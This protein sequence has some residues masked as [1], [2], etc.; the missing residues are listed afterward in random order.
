[1]SDRS[2][3]K[4]VGNTTQ[5]QN[6]GTGEGNIFKDKI[7]GN[8]LRFRR[9]KEGAN[10]RI[11][12]DGDDIVISGSSGGGSVTGGTTTFT[13]L[14]DTPNT[15]VNSAS[16]WVRVNSLATALEFVNP[17]STVPG[18]VDG[19]IQY[20]NNGV[21]G[22]SGLCWDNSTNTY[23]MGVNADSNIL[24]NIS[25]NINYNNNPVFLSMGLRDSHPHLSKAFEFSVTEDMS[26]EIYLGGHF[27][28]LR[29]GGSIG[30]LAGSVDNWGGDTIIQGGNGTQGGNTFICG[31][32]GTQGGGSVTICSGRLADINIISSGSTN[33]ASGMGSINIQSILNITSRSTLP[34]TSLE[35]DI[36]RLRNH[37]TCP[38]GIYV[39]NGTTWQS[40]TIW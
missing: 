1:M 30:I 16:C 38:N 29:A 2:N 26:S 39:N 5:G 10:I 8:N 37:S 12:Q 18:G 4:L 7:G 25:T 13:G 35:G 9:I 14:I 19:S 34:S 15:Y 24:F 32:N 31:G 3:I 28:A 20:N 6:V 11:I 21:L 27:S 22:G 36:I 17:P 33:I 23:S 40:I